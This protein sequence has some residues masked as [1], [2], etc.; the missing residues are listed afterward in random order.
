[1]S[2]NVQIYHRVNN[3]S[4]FMLRADIVFSSAGRKMYEICSVGTP[5]ICICQNGREQTHAFGSP[6]NGFINMGLAE[7]LSN[8]DI[9]NQFKILWQDFELR[10]TMNAM[11]KELRPIFSE[12]LVFGKKNTYRVIT[13]EQAELVIKACY[14]YIAAVNDM[15]ASL[16]EELSMRK[17]EETN[18]E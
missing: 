14:S 3:I 5:C 18:S 12:P 2:H 17:R 11:M 13:K 4:D 1:M 6:K 9:T 16:S 8:E 15:L 10:Q 7:F